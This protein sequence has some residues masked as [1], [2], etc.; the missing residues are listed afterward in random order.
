MG[1]P[2]IPPKALL[3]C[4]ILYSEGI[5]KQEILEVL[6]QKFG[7]TILASPTFDFRETDYYKPEM[8]QRIKRVFL[9]FDHLIPMENIVSI[10]LETNCMEMELFSDQGKR[11]V[12]ID[13][14]YI[15]I[16]KVVLATTKNHQHR[17]YLGE[18]IFTEVTLRYRKGSFIPWEWTYRDYRRE[19]TIL[20][21]NQLREIYRKKIKKPSG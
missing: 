4:G 13:P 21:F 1:K 16:S 7:K 6:E 19:E 9:G 15:T 8:G 3:F 12:N 20:F 10:K 18:G 2:V 11:K 5:H 17:I 14:G